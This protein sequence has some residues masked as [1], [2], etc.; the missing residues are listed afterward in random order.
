MSLSRTM[1]VW[2]RLDAGIS[3]D[4]P[5][6]LAADERRRTQIH[7]QVSK[8]HHRDKEENV[9]LLHGAEAVFFYHG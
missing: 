3:I 9:D 7:R 4:A 5:E 2:A 6:N 8:I 1:A